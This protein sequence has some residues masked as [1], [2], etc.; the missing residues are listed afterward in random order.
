MCRSFLFF[1]I[2]HG[3]TVLN[4]ETVNLKGFVLYYNDIGGV[5]S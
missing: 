5:Q 3:I 2:L 4:T 1:E